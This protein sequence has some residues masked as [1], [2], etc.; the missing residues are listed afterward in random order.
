MR[1][2]QVCFESLE[3]IFLVICICQMGLFLFFLFRETPLQQ[4]LYRWLG[5][6]QPTACDKDFKLS[7]KN[8]DHGVLITQDSATLSTKSTDLRAQISQQRALEPI[9]QHEFAVL[10]HL[11]S[12]KVKVLFW[13]VFFKQKKKKTK[14]YTSGS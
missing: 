11:G 1:T 9:F 14:K 3:C 10:S 7:R 4:H 6:F 8:Y 2:T 13:G 5:Q 12:I